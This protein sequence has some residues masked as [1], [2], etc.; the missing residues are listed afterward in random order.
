MKQF[1]LHGKSEVFLFF[2]I[3]ILMNNF[4]IFMNRKSL[5]MDVLSTN[6]VASTKRSIYLDIEPCLRTI[7][8]TEKLRTQTERRGSRFYHYL[9]HMKVSGNIAQSFNTNIFD[10]YSTVFENLDDDL[11]KFSK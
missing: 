1:L 10:E 11:D 7:C 4:L 8:R 6:I 3:I 9:R 2:F 5:S